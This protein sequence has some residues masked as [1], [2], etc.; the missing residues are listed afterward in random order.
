MFK[1]FKPQTPFFLFAKESIGSFVNNL[2][3]ENPLISKE[4]MLERLQESKLSK[5]KTAEKSYSREIRKQFV[6]RG[7]DEDTRL[8]KDIVIESFDGQSKI[9]DDDFA[10][11]D[12]IDSLDEDEDEAPEIN[13]NRKLLKTG[14]TKNPEWGKTSE[15]IEIYTF[16][17]NEQDEY[18]NS[19]SWWYDKLLAAVQQQVLTL[20]Y[21][22]DDGYQ[23][24]FVYDFNVEAEHVYPYARLRLGGQTQIVMLQ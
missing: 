3:D 16:V 6:L 20:T 10:R 15:N 8:T 22:D 21:I 17:N 5:S 11:D 12:F 24:D 18:Y 19:E 13:W 23:S 7:G 14:K 2:L 1:V 4:E 9:S